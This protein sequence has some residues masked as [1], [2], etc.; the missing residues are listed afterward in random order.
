MKYSHDIWLLK[1]VEYHGIYHGNSSWDINQPFQWSNS[2][3]MMEYGHGMRLEYQNCN[4]NATGIAYSLYSSSK[5]N[6]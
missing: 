6:F 2:C 3:D 1:L 4:I 5:S